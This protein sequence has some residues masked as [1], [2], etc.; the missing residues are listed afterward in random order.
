MSTARR[1]WQRTEARAAA[2]FGAR[3]QYG[4]GSSGRLDETRS[5]STHPTL[6]VESKLRASSAVRSLHDASRALAVREEKTPVLALFDKGRPGFLL[7]VHVD[8]M[9]TVLAEFAAALDDAGRDR[10]EGMVRVA[11]ARQRGE[12]PCDVD[13]PAGWP[14][15]AGRSAEPGDLGSIEEGGTVDASR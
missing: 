5:D 11:Y 3:R 13:P 15:M 8:D 2:L 6:F 14:P 4:S 1:T 7:V 12:L 9:A 10:L